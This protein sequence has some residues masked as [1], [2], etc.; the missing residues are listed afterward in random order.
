MGVPFL[1][2][3]PLDPAICEDSDKGVPFVL[4]HMDSPTSKAFMEIVR[5][6]ESSLKSGEEEKL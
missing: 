4:E 1:G 5:R 6:I 3:I 2:R